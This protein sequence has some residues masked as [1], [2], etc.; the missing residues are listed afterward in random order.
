MTDILDDECI[1][2]EERWRLTPKGIF[3]VALE[4]VKLVDDINDFRIDAAWKIFDLMMERN[5]YIS[6]EEN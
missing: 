5:G 6:K 1:N 3:V 2:E 4:T